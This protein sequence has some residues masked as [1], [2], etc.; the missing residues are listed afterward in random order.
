VA[1]F[2]V[3]RLSNRDNLVI[4]S[5]T[6]P[7]TIAAHR[8]LERN[9]ELKSENLAITV[10]N[11]KLR[12][13]VE[14]GDPSVVHRMQA[15]EKKMIEKQEELMELHKRKGDHQQLIIDLN[16]KVGDLQKQLEQKN[17]R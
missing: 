1:L 12:K 17:L 8:M 6:C 10:E 14:I 9:Y 4:N 2:S 11:E 16:A 7:R 15:L 3:I 13:G 5:I